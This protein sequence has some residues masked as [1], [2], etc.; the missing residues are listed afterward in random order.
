MTSPVFVCDTSEGW[1]YDAAELLGVLAMRAGAG[2]VTTSYGNDWSLLTMYLDT[3][4]G[5][6]KVWQTPKGRWKVHGSALGW[7]ITL[8]AED[9]QDLPLEQIISV[10]ARILDTRSVL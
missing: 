4:I 8:R 3:R 7:Q 2:S 5:M 6:L 9:A 1:E 10:M